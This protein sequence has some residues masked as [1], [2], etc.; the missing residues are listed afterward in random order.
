M[1]LEL[2]H[3]DGDVD[4]SELDQLD[5]PPPYTSSQLLSSS[6]NTTNLVNVDY[7]DIQDDDINNNIRG[8]QITA[9]GD[10]STSLSLPAADTVVSR[11]TA[12]TD[13]FRHQFAPETVQSVEL[14]PKEVLSEA[15]Q[16]TR[17]YGRTS[18]T[19][20]RPTDDEIMSSCSP[21]SAALEMVQPLEQLSEGL[22]SLNPAP[23]LKLI[24]VSFKYIWMD[25]QQAQASTGQLGALVGS[26]AQLLGAL[27]EQDC[28]ENLK[29][30]D[31]APLDDLHA[32]VIELSF[33]QTSD[34]IY[35]AQSSRRYIP[36]FA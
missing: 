11:K 34:T 36:V 24:W 12:P 26:V 19:A 22:L 30:L 28:Q 32:L 17:I 18:S 4:E 31:P 35:S 21:T 5:L 9:A 3:D 20:S 6:S 2:V 29:S 23:R 27:Y 15:M 7:H 10:A 8:L 16:D 33:A 14:L 1:S 13:P 25:F